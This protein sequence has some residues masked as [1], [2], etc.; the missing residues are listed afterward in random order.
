MLKLRYVE[1]LLRESVA[2]F[3]VNKFAGNFFPD[4][5]LPLSRVLL[6]IALLENRLYFYLTGRKYLWREKMRNKKDQ[7]H[8][9]NFENC[10]KKN[11]GKLTLYS[12]NRGITE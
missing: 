11:S 2:T 1:G 7:L 4:I 6:L 9:R 3:S 12:R 5:S 8:L 10:G